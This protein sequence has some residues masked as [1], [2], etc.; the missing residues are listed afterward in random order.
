VGLPGRA[1]SAPALGVAG[2]A[3][4]LGPRGSGS[5]VQRRRRQCSGPA[6]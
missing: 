2:L 5:H 3:H 6:P 4:W 1:R